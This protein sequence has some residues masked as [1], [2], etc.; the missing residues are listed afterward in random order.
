MGGHI[1]V[2]QPTVTFCEV[3]QC[4]KPTDLTIEY[5]SQNAAHFACMADILKDEHWDCTSENFSEAHK[6]CE[7]M[8]FEFQK[9]DSHES[10]SK[11]SY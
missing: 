2:T 3:A 6:A 1:E 11:S 4:H 5:W 7:K 8:G 10:H 9:S